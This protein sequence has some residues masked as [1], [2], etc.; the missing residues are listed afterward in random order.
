MTLNDLNVDFTVASLLDAEY[1]RNGTTDIVTI[2]TRIY[3]RPNQGVVSNDDL[4]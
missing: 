3:T 1:L 4:E 2:L